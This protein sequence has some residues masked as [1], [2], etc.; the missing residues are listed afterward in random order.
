MHR[1]LPTIVLP[2]WAAHF[3]L[4]SG[5][6]YSLPAQKP[7]TASKQLSSAPVALS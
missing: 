1:M 2:L 6:T 7:A 4:V 3:V 5:L